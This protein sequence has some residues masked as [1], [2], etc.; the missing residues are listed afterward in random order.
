MKASILSDTCLVRRKK[1][2]EGRKKKKG[3]ER[4]NKKKMG[5]RGKMRKKEGGSSNPTW[6]E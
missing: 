1:T 6:L 3:K 5:Q 4:R 2:K